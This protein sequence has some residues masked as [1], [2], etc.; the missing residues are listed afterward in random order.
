MNKKTGRYIL[1]LSVSYVLVMFGSRFI[2]LHFGEV[3]PERSAVELSR[4]AAL[5]ARILEL[6]ARTR[7]LE[8]LNAKIANLE[9]RNEHLA[10]EVEAVTNAQL[11]EKY[12]QAPVPVETSIQMA[13]PLIRDLNV[14][15]DPRVSVK[16]SSRMA[17]PVS[18]GTSLMPSRYA[19][20]EM[21][22]RGDS[23][24]KV[25]RVFGRPNAVH[26][27]IFSEVW[28]Y[29][30]F[31]RKSVTFKNGTVSEWTSLPIEP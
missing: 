9:A 4:I 26:D 22:H 11:Q 30:E 3:F 31:G 21:V 14:V 5:D 16:T 28:H 7:E 6:E 29:D 17:K 8:T 10:E 2:T 27:Y 13:K 18:G 24:E 19:N 25:R 23:M 15:E 12:V 1:L 20:Q